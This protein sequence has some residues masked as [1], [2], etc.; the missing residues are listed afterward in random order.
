MVD[1]MLRL[2][3][4][5]IGVWQPNPEAVEKILK[6]EGVTDRLQIEMNDYIA[7]LMQ[8]HLTKS[9]GSQLKDY[10]RMTKELENLADCCKALFYIQKNLVDTGKLPGAETTNKIKDYFSDLISEYELL[11]T[12]MADDLDESIF[13][14]EVIDESFKAKAIDLNV[15]QMNILKAIYNEQKFEGSTHWIAEMMFRFNQIHKHTANFYES[16]KKCISV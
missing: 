10:L 2:T 15:K 13:T 4:E 14:N 9:Q 6:Y 5:V 1:S 12:D 16:Y 8:S 11:F 3:Q 7:K